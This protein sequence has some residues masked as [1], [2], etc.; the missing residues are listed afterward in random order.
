MGIRLSDFDLYRDLLYEKSGLAITPD[1]T[2]LL[3]SRLTPVA[4]KWNFASLDAMTVALRALPDPGLVNDIIEAMT[5]NETSF[6]RDQ[7]PFTIFE[8][9]VLPALVAARSKGTKKIRIWCAA[10]STGQEPYSL[11]MLLKE[12]EALWRGI[13]IE[14]VGT[15]ISNEALD[16]ARAGAY[17]Q[18]EVQRGLSISH[19]MKYF[20]QM[21][22]K[23]LI[24]DEIKKLVKFE[25]FNLLD[26][27]KKFGSFDVI[28]CRNVL[29]YFDEKTK[30]QVFAKMAGLLPKDGYLFLG[31]AETTLGITDKFKPSEQ[32][33]GLYV[34]P[35]FPVAACPAAAV[36]PVSSAAAR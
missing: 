19:L 31:G 20:K 11:L 15:D 34:K 21:G 23:W 1:K 6:F 13:T 22:E 14:L 29:I 25:Y 17:S 36:P 16:I 30:G 27:M 4:K 32:Y 7:K 3:D 5:T 2:Y 9:T 24:S 26:D 12:K 33:R 10:A 35:D 28:F 8:Q 18:F